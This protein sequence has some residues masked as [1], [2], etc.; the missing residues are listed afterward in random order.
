MG[1]DGIDS[2]WPYSAGPEFL[3]H[4]RSFRRRAERII[5]LDTENVTDFDSSDL[6]AR[7]QPADAGG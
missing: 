1:F 3:V 6:D 2:S 7:A 4:G 5:L